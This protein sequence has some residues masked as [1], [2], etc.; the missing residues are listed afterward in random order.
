MKCPFL[1]VAFPKDV[2]PNSDIV[3]LLISE[4]VISYLGTPRYRTAWHHATSFTYKLA[5]V[6]SIDEWPTLSS[7]Y[8]AR[9]LP[10]TSPRY[11]HDCGSS[12]SKETQVTSVDSTLS[13]VFLASRPGARVSKSYRRSIPPDYRRLAQIETRWLQMGLRF[14][15][16]FHSGGVESR[17]GVL[18][19]ISRTGKVQNQS[20]SPGQTF[21]G[22]HVGRKE[23]S[24]VTSCHSMGLQG[25]TSR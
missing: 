10:D 20:P 6:E 4:P 18:T 7:D 21:P 5:V 25:T 14:V 11:L 17:Y 19:T 9:S 13:A 15:T 2:S 16:F 1:G 22:V 3:D 24:V 23:W 8:Q 12:R